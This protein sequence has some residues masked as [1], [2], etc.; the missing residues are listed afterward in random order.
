MNEKL[1][2]RKFQAWLVAS[3]FEAA[4]IAFSLITKDPKMTELLTPWWGGITMVYIGGNAW[5]HVKAS[6][7]TGEEEK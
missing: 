2:S 5:Q 4:A 7:A 1:K 3:V 6:Q